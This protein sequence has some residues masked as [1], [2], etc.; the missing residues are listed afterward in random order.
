M[1]DRKEVPVNAGCVQ[2]GYLDKNPG[3]KS[4]TASLNLIQE[5]TRGG[6]KGKLPF[7]SLLP[8]TFYNNSYQK[9]YIYETFLCEPATMLSMLSVLTHL[10]LTT[11]H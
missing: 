6:R 4:L 2:L 7:A 9:Y 5:G 11:T 3:Q 8:G 10:I 1:W